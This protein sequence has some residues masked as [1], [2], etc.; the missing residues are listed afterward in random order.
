MAEAVFSIAEIA[1]EL[2]KSCEEALE[3][4]HDFISEIDKIEKMKEE[5]AVKEN[6]QT[7]IGLQDT[8]SHARTYVYK[9][10][11][12]AQYIKRHVSKVNRGLQCSPPNYQPLKEFITEIGSNLA[13][14]TE[15]YGQFSD[16]CSKA[17]TGACDAEWQCKEDARE[18]KNKKIAAKVVGGTATTAAIA[19][20]VGTGVALSVV[21]GVFTF[22]IGTIIG[23][24]ATAAGATAAGV[25]AGAIGAAATHHIASDYEEKEKVLEEL[26][27]SFRSLQQIGGDLERRT[28]YI[29]SHLKAISANVDNARRFIEDEQLR[30]LVKKI[31]G[32]KLF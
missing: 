11:Y 12:L 8:I 28:G 27:E 32:L 19:A 4:A 9:V 14:A 25:G 17:I 13:K 18:A 23:L 10:Q 6:R 31:L 30:E 20:G 1:D 3:I 29:Q 16:S 7:Y 15:F 21:A 26:K 5:D 2:P 24:G 22:G